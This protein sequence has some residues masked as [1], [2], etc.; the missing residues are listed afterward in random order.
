MNLLRQFFFLK[1]NLYMMRCDIIK[2]SSKVR[3]T[4]PINSYFMHRLFSF[5]YKI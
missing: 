3:L 1:R 4:T 2:M 5:G